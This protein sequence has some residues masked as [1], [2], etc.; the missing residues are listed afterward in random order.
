MWT[1]YVHNASPWRCLQLSEIIIHYLAACNISS[2]ADYMC[3]VI[4]L[5]IILN[6]FLGQGRNAGTPPLEYGRY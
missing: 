4:G 3:S 2:W 1:V 6:D 5:E